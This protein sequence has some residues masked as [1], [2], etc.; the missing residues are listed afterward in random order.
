MIIDSFP[1]RK[2]QYQNQSYLYFGGTAYLGLPMHKQFQ[3]ILLKNIQHWG[4]TYGSSR[5][6][7]V[8]LSAYEAGETFLANHIQAAA[9]LTVSSGMLAGKLVLETLEKLTDSFYHFPNT[10]AA[11]KHPASRPFFI[12]QKI[13]PLLLDERVEK[14]TIL[15]DVVPAFSLQAVDLSML[16][17]ISNHKEITLVLDESHS[18]GILGAKGCGFFSNN[19]LSIIL[20]RKIMISSL[21]KSFGLTGG[22]IASDADFINQIRVSECFASSAGMNPAFVQTLADAETIYDQQHQKLLENL[23][24]I[25]Q[26]LEQNSDAVFNP[27]YPIIYPKKMGVNEFLEKEKI[28]ITQFK[29][30]NLSENLNRIVFSAHHK[31]KDLDKIINLLNRY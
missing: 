30:G 9:A 12:D 25:D 16:N 7:N 10:H 13:N 24:Y 1:A 5:N 23:A 11:L 3:K 20:K 19:T 31:K 27:Q 28:I 26:K 29:Y 21:G 8:Q 2:I 18:L 22:V 15:T 14:I 4:T 6:S 17:K